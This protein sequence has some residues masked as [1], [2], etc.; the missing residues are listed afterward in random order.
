LIGVG[1]AV[2]NLVFPPKEM[3]CTFAD[4]SFA[5]A[6]KAVEEYEAAKGTPDE[7]VKKRLADYELT[8]SEGWT[9][10]CNRSKESHRFYGLIFSGVGIVGLLGLLL[11]AVIAFFGFR[12]KKIA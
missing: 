8:A 9:D 11:G 5:K 6:K 4:E 3:T 10:S 12:K 7:D 1:G 2:M